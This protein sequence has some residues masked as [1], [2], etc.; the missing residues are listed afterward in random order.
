LTLW[1]LDILLRTK[2]LVVANT[3]VL[4]RF[5]GLKYRTMKVAYLLHIGKIRMR[6]SYI[7]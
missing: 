1:V 7:P 2:L 4:N 3:I 5:S 6:N